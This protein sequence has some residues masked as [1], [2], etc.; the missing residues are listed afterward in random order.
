MKELKKEYKFKGKDGVDRN[1]LIV[2]QVEIKDKNESH[3]F[4]VVMIHEGNEHRLC[5]DCNHS[6]LISK[7]K[8]RRGGSLS[9]IRMSYDMANKAI[10]I[11]TAYIKFGYAIHRTSEFP[12]RTSKMI[13][14]VDV[15]NIEDNVIT[16]IKEC[17]K[18]P[19]ITTSI[20]QPDKVNPKLMLDIA[21]GR[22]VKGFDHYNIPSFRYSKELCI[23]LMDNV[24]RGIKGNI[25]K[26]HKPIVEPKVEKDE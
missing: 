15:K 17:I 11:K 26:L 12:V 16:N 19:K 25:N 14:I 2:A 23:A 21:K 5:D 22:L 3:Q 10:L 9:T 6:I 18:I 7:S 13:T 8:R 24:F 4:G 1:V 20:C